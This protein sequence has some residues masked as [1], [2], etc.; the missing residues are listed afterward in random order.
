[1]AVVG[2]MGSSIRFSYTALGDAVNL[3]SRLESLTKSYGCEFL[4][5]ED[6]Y[7]QLSSQQQQDL[8]CIDRVAVSGR[9]QA[10]RI[11]TCC[12]HLDNVQREDF[13][14]ALNLYIDGHFEQ[15]AGIWQALGEIDPC[16]AI[17]ASRCTLLA[18]E[19]AGLN[20]E[21]LNKEQRGWDGIYRFEHK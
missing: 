8:H 13:A 6:S 15:A 20:K 17:L 2:N 3:A 4:I 5:S 12:Q 1:M 11:Y 16:A 14:R 9:N 10:T 21:Q 7:Q 18:S 19:Y